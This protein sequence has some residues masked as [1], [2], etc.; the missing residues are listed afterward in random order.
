VAQRFNGT[1]ANYLELGTTPPITAWSACGWAKLSADRNALS[2]LLVREDNTPFSYTSIGTQ[3]DGTTLKVENDAMETSLLSL[4]VGDVFFWCITAAGAGTN[5]L[6]GYAA[7]M[8]DTALS[9]AQRNIVSDGA[10]TTYIRLGDNA[11]SEPY[12][13]WIDNVLVFDTV[14]TEAEVNAQWR[15]RVP[16]KAPWSW[17][18]ANETTAVYTDKSGNGRNW[19]L[20]GT[21]LAI[22]DGAGVGWGAPPIIL[23]RQGPV[24]SSP[25]VID[26]TSTSVRPRVT[27]T[28]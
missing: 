21:A 17:L 19:T 3:A 15:R 23:S 4:S 26:I 20:S 1:A 8:G 24:L 2:T 27:F 22:E 13:G 12:D 25:T 16:I 11:Y 9:T 18:T 14:L 28:I 10:A 6:K 7:K 5:T